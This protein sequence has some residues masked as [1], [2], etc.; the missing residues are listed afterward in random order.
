[1]SRKDQSKKSTEK[2][3]SKK[4]APKTPATSK[5]NSGELNDEQLDR[6]SGGAMSYHNEV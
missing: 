6:L 5:R 3:E 2:P 1:M 4:L